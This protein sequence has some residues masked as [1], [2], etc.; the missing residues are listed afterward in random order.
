MTEFEFWLLIMIWYPHV[1]PEAIEVYSH[2]SPVAQVS[3][4][5]MIELS[6]DWEKTF[7][8]I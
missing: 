3:I 7:D 6:T 8:P 2:V 4:L 5:Q 1:T